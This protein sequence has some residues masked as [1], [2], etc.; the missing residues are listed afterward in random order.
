V[1]Y[2]PTPKPSVVINA[3]VLSDADAEFVQVKVT[4]DGF[5]FKCRVQAL[6]YSEFFAE[7]LDQVNPDGGW[8]DITIIFGEEIEEEDIRAVLSYLHDQVPGRHDSIP[9]WNPHQFGLS[10][11][12]EYDLA[13]R[14][15][16][17]SWQAAVLASLSAGDI[18]G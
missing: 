15:R 10:I 3:K 12:D 5:V 17:E 1:D 6:D 11:L 4:E 16:I 13:S 8:L 7:C 2:V 14:F 9:A 18:V